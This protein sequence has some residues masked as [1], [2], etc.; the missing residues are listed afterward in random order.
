MGHVLDWSISK[1]K[2]WK[3]ISIT[4]GRVLLQIDYICSEIA[5]QVQSTR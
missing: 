1:S 3:E 2:G 4:D 5:L